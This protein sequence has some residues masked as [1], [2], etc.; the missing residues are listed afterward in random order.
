M[1]FVCLALP[2]IAACGQYN[3]NR[4]ALVPRAT[5]R[6]TSGQPLDGR[7]Q[8]SVGASSVAHL[9]APEVGEDANAGIEV[10]GTQLFGALKGRIGKHIAF[11]L[12]YENGLDSGAKKLNASQPDVNE[13]NV[14]GYGASIDVTIPT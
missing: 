14:S 2:L 5:P 8:L 10:P 11:G 1:R 4:A 7:G 3:Y 12:L 6:I 13:G 9:T